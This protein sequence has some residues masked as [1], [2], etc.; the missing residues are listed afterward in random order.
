MLE[1]L[2]EGSQGPVAK[3]ILG[4]VI[5]SFALAGV[6]SYIASPSEQLAATVNGESISRAE[7]DKAYQNE[8]AR[9]ENQFGDAFN[10][11]AADPSYMAQF[12][13][14]VLDR[15]VSERLLDQAAEQ[16]G[17]RIS[18]AQLK[19]QIL[20]M[21][22]FQVDGRFDNDRY[23]AVLSRAHFQPSQ[24]R[25]MMRNDLTRQ[26]LQNAL[27]GSEFA[28]PSEA[29]LLA[30]LNQQTRDVRYV[31]IPTAN[32]VA[33]EK[34]SSEDLK[35][36]Y[37][38]HKDSFKTEE[39]VDVEYI[40]VD[41]DEL[42][43]TIAVSP[44]EIDQ[45]YKANSQTYTQPE[46]RKVA[47]ILVNFGDDEAAALTKAE[48]LLA[49]LNQGE[50][51]AALAAESSDDSFSGEKGG[52][53]DWFESGVMDPAFDEAAF[54][55]AQKGDVS[56]IVKSAFGYHLIKLLDVQTAQVKPLDQ[57]SEQISQQLRHEKAQTA[58]YEQ[59]QKVAELSFEVPDS[60]VEVASET[61]LKLET[62]KG[63]SRTNANAVLGQAQVI[64]KL[65]DPEFIAEGLNSDVIQLADNS[66]VVVRVTGHS[67][68]IVKP[69]EVVESQIASN[70]TQSRA[71]QAA[72]AYADK[73]IAALKS[74]EGLD[75]LLYQQHLQFTTKSK[76]T[77]DSQELEPQVI[78]HL[79]M[80]AK[81]LAQKVA[82]RIST[83]NGDQLVLQLTAVNEVETVESTE[84]QRW[85]Q[86]LASIKTEASYQTLIDL[87]KSKAEIKTLL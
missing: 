37:Q 24:F 15:M 60:L 20:K 19:S 43:K 85:L 61:G 46:K 84:T 25:D 81:P 49:K 54:A 66:S 40:L 58:F 10:Q 1:K 64:S 30:K 41:A 78:R 8:R 12:R 74:G 29:E 7:F 75:D 56:P 67:A 2:R 32:F 28:L 17:L 31:T 80:M 82:G 48:Q 34:P 33:A 68:A 26:Q 73:L 18:D 35:A 51:F 44:E 69:F 38:A 71:T 57:V 14:N 9:L 83:M 53:L 21:P 22:E 70:L 4:L 39:S 62:V 87:L 77:R 65:F 76:L 86:Q 50:D 23:L 63:L 42:A 55:L 79:F 3:I 36:Y 11:L 13:N 27:L 45:F 16:Y 5:L 6:G 59:A 72:Q 47:H 52:E